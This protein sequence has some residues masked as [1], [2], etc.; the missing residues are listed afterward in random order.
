MST[1]LSGNGSLDGQI[2]VH[3]ADMIVKSYSL[4]RAHHACLHSKNCS[5]TLLADPSNVFA[6]IDDSPYERNAKR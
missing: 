2:R 6:E 4:Q 1:E 3:Y 5:K